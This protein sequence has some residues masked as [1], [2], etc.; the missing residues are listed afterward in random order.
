MNDPKVDGE[1]GTE[2]HKQTHSQH[3]YIHRLSEFSRSHSG[4]AEENANYTF[5]KLSIK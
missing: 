2:I 1:G 4:T 5:F 3:I